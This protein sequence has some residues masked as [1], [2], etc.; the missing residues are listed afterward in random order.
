MKTSLKIIMFYKLN[1]ILLLKVCRHLEIVKMIY[2]LFR[3][4]IITLTK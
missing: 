3:K 1:M 2:Q 4:S